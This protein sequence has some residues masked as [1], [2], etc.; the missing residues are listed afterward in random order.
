[1][2][3][4]FQGTAAPL[5]LDLPGAAQVLGFSVHQMRRFVADLPEGFPPP[6][7]LRG[8]IF[9]KRIELERWAAGDYTP[10][11]PVAQPQTLRLAPLGS[12]RPRGR[13]RKEVATAGRA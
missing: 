8:R 4:D 3:G 12:G 2:T 9:I 5:L 10:P 6:L 7:R 1:M 13:P 11:Q